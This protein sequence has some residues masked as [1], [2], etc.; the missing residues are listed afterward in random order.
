METIRQRFYGLYLV[1]CE[2]VG[3]KPQFLEDEAVEQD[4]AKAAALNWLEHLA[5]DPDLARDTRV[6]VPIFIDRVGGKTRL[7]A[8]LGV[9]LARLEA[10]YA[11]PPKVR[12]KDEGGPWQEVES[13]Q[14]GESR[15]VIPVD[16]F[17]EI[18]LPGSARPFRAASSF[19]PASVTFE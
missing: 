1:S 14:L 19:N 11:R 4:V 15:Y 12:P 6:S 2:D 18:E 13:Y 10:S 3:M 5:D 9:R 8:T 17:A 7:W 16:E